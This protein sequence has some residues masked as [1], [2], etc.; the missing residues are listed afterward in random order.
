MRSLFFLTFVAESYSLCGKGPVDL[1]GMEPFQVSVNCPGNKDKD[2]IEM[3]C[4]NVRTPGQNA[5]LQSQKSN[6]FYINPCG[7]YKTTIEE[8][9]GKPGAGLEVTVDIKENN[10][11]TDTNCYSLGGIPNAKFDLIDEDNPDEGIKATYV[12]GSNN[13]CPTAGYKN[14][15]TVYKS[16]TFL[17]H[18]H[19][20]L[21]NN[22]MYNNVDEPGGDAACSYTLH[23]NTIHACPKYCVTGNNICNGNGICGHSDQ[24]CLCYEGYI[25]KHCETPG[26]APSTSPEGFTIAAGLLTAGLFLL[27]GLLAFLLYMWVKLRRLAPVDTE[28][29]STLTSK[30][31]ELGQIT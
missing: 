1:G 13:N 27:A 28:A 6:T 4:V 25:G 21:Q 23:R 8:C 2:F 22:D 9:K 16:R 31:N 17:V 3:G 15:A 14:G 12:G 18:Y 20:S 30:F 11:D 26:Y 19:C 7:E 10:K 5:K 29:Y 24:P